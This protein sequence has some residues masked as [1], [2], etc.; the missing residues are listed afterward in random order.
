MRRVTNATKSI[1]FVNL[2][3]RSVLPSVWTSC[4][5]PLHHKLCFLLPKTAMPTLSFI[6][7]CSCCLENSLDEDLEPKKISDR[8][9]INTVTVCN[10]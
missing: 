7:L 5:V 4:T 2:Q 9:Q 8:G 1:R 3:N 6:S 10:Q